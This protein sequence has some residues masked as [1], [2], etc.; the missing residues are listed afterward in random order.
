MDRVMSDE[1]KWSKINEH[2]KKFMKNIVEK[3][4]ND[5]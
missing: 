2:K 5:S 4:D 1:C 3:F